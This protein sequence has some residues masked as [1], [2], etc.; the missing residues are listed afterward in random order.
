MVGAALRASR[1]ARSHRSHRLSL[2]G[3]RGRRPRRRAPTSRFSSS[4]S[5]PSSSRRCTSARAR[6]SSCPSR[7]SPSSSWTTSSLERRFAS[8]FVPLWNHGAEFAFFVFFSWLVGTL[9]TALQRE[10]AARA[11][12]LEHDLASRARC[13]PPCCRRAASTGRSSSCR[14]VPSGLR[15][16]GRRVGP[17]SGA[18]GGEPL[19][20]DR[21][22]LRQGHARRAPH[23]RFHRLAARPPRLRPSAP[24][25]AR[26]RAFDVAPR[27]VLRKPLRDGVSRRRR[28]RRSPV[29]QRGPRARVPSASSGREGGPRCLPSTGPVLGLLPDAAF[30]E[31]RVPFPAGSSL[32]LYTDGSDRVRGPGR[33][34]SWG[35]PGSSGSW[36]GSEPP[37]RRT[38]SRRSLPPPSRT[39]RERRPSTTS[40]SSA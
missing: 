29:R 38:S 22:R 9:R 28:G 39:R 30:R 10:A 7:A 34:A 14:R 8:A 16:R 13:R 5:C 2:L 26:R 21:G 37:R 40:P 12:R 20:R 23:G 4:I 6:A 32:V 31:E 35:A 18:G 36:S 15:R 25:R 1:P 17:R 27:L 11:D 24:R 33:P 19:R 3:S